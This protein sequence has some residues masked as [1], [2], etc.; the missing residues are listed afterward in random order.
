MHPTALENGKR[1]FDT[2]VAN[3]DDSIS[4]V[5]IGAQNINGSL[6]DVAPSGKRYLGVDF[7][8][9]KGVDVVLDDPYVLPFEDNSVDVIICNSCFEHSEFFWLLFLE[10][11]RVLKPAGLFYLNAPSNGYF[12]RYPV[13]CWRFYPDSGQ[14]MERWAQRNGYRTALLESFVSNQYRGLND[15]FAWNDFVAVFVKDKNESY[16]F[17]TRI[18]DSFTDFTNGRVMGESGYRNERFMSEDRMK[19]NMIANTIYGSLRMG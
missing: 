4:I 10:V 8:A 9:G 12:H 15:E 5:D 3:Q 7:V 2:Y 11:V 1:F 19:L 6:K 17:P 18:V 13:D 14:A 16:R